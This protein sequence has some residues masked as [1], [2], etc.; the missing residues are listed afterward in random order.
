MR[1]FLLNIYVIVLIVT[2][3][4]MPI[5]FV[6]SLNITFHAYVE[7]HTISFIVNIVLY[8]I[9]IIAIINLLYRIYEK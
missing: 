6:D 7:T 9:L 3:Y 2:L 1:T 4:Y 8:M 5:A